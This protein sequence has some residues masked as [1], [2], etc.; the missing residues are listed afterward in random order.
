MSR[1]GIQA[2]AVDGIGIIRE[3]DDL[4]T[5][6]AGHCAATTW[7]DGRTGLADGD[8]VVVT[9]KVVSKA[10]G[11]VVAAD[12]RDEAIG[13]ETARVVATKQA[14]R[15]DTR[16]VQTHHGLVMAAAG[17]DA[18]NVE[19]GHV[20]LLPTD[21]DASARRIRATMQELTGARLGVVVTDTMGRPW[22]MG[23]TD[24]AIGAAGVLVLDDYTGRV[25][26]FGRTLEMTVVAVAD[27][28]AAAT[29][30]V[31]GK[32][33]NRPAA[34]VRGLAAH[35]TDDDGPGARAVIRPLDEDLFTLGSAE[36][37]AEGRRSA[38][39]ARR[40]VR[41]FTDE[42][43]PVGVL[44]A[45]VAAAVSAP[46]PHHSEPWR[47]IALRP[48][49][50]RDRL[51]DAMRDRWAADL[52]GIDG[53]DDDAVARRLR[54]GDVL[55]HAPVIVLPFV[56]LDGAAHAYPDERRRGFE[57]DLFVVAG[58]AA[59]QNLMVALAAEGWASAW[60]SSTVFCP[61]TVRE[62]LDLPASWQPLGAVAVGRAASAAPERAA[63]DV[64]RFLDQRSPPGG[65]EPLTG[66]TLAS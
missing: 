40:T 60:I 46:A 32:L 35:V 6:L 34:I 31:K 43:V 12:S 55:R 49:A 27:E 30:L 13:A 11:R 54:R 39:F 8:I 29:D 28:V 41:A 64:A 52:V 63:R 20:V 24:V 21:P 51:L 38:P 1:A 16:I 10:E 59:V 2:V 45:A 56:D 14:P 48:G 50:D 17:V 5:L 33:D 25:D 65:V 53:Y 58:G 26:S 18:S 37:L 44:E 57:R 3:G 23:V 9:S 22:R 19:A 47:F 66:S 36:A 42:P 7:P 4:G 61:E 62:A 15:G